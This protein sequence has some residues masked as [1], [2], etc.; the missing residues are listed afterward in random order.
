MEEKDKQ[1]G[2]SLLI[3]HLQMYLSQSI[4]PDQDKKNFIEAIK[5]FESMLHLLNNS[6]NILHHNVKSNKNY[7]LEH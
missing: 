3:Q 1:A 4:N 6:R 5:Q 2:I 7:T